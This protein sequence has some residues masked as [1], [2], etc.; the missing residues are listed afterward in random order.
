MLQ[1]QSCVHCGS[2]PLQMF[3]RG[4]LRE[5]EASREVMELSTVRAQ[6]IYC[7]AHHGQKNGLLHKPR[8]GFMRWRT[9]SQ[10][11]P[12]PELSVECFIYSRPHGHPGL[13]LVCQDTR[14]IGILNNVDNSELKLPPPQYKRFMCTQ[15]ICLASHTLPVTL[16]YLMSLSLCF[17]SDLSSLNDS[18]ERI[19]GPNSS[20][21][22][23]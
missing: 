17:T 21:H 7:P 3:T 1:R 15:I 14:G 5:I 2:S 11:E 10:E 12:R 8:A 6:R 19:P 9:M 20:W 18:T 4:G 13:Y 22:R 23:F 16:C